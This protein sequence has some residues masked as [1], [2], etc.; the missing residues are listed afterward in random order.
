MDSLDNGSACRTGL[1]PPF[2]LTFPTVFFFFA[3]A[4]YL[5]HACELIMIICPWSSEP[6]PLACS[7]A[8]LFRARQTEAGRIRARI[9]TAE[10]STVV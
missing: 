2:S 6:W 4:Y 8:V 3:F 7:S 5:P 9:G 10:V 1:T